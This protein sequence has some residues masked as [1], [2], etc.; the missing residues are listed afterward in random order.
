MP[1]YD[2]FIS[3]S[4]KDRAIADKIVAA[5]EAT[6]HSCWIAP[7]NIPYGTPY[8]R[9]IM[10]GIDESTTFI[11]LITDN[12]VRSNDVLNEV[13]NA[14]AEKK[15]IIPI[16][17]SDVKLSRELNYY[18]SRR[19]WLIVNPN[20]SEEI[21]RKLD[22]DIKPNKTQPISQPD[23]ID[24]PSKGNSF[25]GNLKSH[26]S[27][28][29]PLINI[30]LVL[31][32]VAVLLLIFFQFFD[33]LFLPLFLLTAAFATS[34]I[35][36]LAR[37]NQDGFVWLFTSSFFLVLAFAYESAPSVQDFKFFK[38]IIFI[39]SY[40]PLVIAILSPLLLLLKHKNIPWYKSCKKISTM[41]TIA[42]T[43]TGLFWIGIIFFDTF[44]MH[45]LPSNLRFWI[46][47]FTQALNIS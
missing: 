47:N 37:D 1:K 20:S 16:R 31:A 21:I 19:Q 4:T 30:Y 2:F 23:T 35:L 9:A 5:I 12:S 18:L 28:R 27:N 33:P 15:K 26:W 11:V 8:A 36:Q 39:L 13:D 3:Y 10:N 44:S 46:S 14:H 7:R 45:G 32:T 40:L 41:G 22:L 42:A 29:N 25:R 34:G 24:N 38:E 43:I 17:F 6:G